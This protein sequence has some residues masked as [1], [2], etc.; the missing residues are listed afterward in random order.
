MSRLQRRS[1]LSPFNPPQAD[2]VANVLVK[3]IS[4]SNA[5]KRRSHRDLLVVVRMT[6]TPSLEAVADTSRILLSRTFTTTVSQASPPC[7]S[8]VSRCEPLGSQI[9]TDVDNPIYLTSS[10]DPKNGGQP[11]YLCANEADEGTSRFPVYRCASDQGMKEWRALVA[12]RGEVYACFSA[13]QQH[14]NANAS[15]V[16]RGTTLIHREPL[17]ACF[18]V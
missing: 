16:S 6:P 9:D 5:Q 8:A 17:R 3:N 2:I 14:R 7:F 11:Q 4:M 15:S 12:L 18:D 1:L 13:T 10:P